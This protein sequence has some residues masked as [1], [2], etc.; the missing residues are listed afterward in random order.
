MTMESP[1]TFLTLFA[2]VFSSAASAALSKLP[3]ELFPF[4]ALIVRA[5]SDA[6]SGVIFA[7]EIPHHYTSPVLHIST[8]IPHC[9]F[10]HEREYIE[11]VRQ[12][13][14]LL[15]FLFAEG[16]HCDVITIKQL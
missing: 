2:A 1:S 13:I 10:L 8:V 5:L 15:V 6:T 3:C 16:L 11:I 9:E 7:A 12:K 14:L 4:A